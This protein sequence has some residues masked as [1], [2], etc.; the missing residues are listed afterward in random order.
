MTTG[1]QAQQIDLDPAFKIVLLIVVG[2]VSVSLLI[3]VVLAIVG[4]HNPD[5]KNLFAL[6]SDT[7]KLGFGAIVGLLGG[8]KL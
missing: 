2:L 7:F 4:A 5:A 6:C 1:P 3:M 8:K